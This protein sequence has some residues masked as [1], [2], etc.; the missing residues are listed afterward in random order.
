MDLIGKKWISLR[1]SPDDQKAVHWFVPLSAIE[2]FSVSERETEDEFRVEVLAYV[3]GKPYLCTNSRDEREAKDSV[4][5]II[6][7]IERN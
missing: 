3:A 2:R 5:Y 6:D 4:Q 1:E 7:A